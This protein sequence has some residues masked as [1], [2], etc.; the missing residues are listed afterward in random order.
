[1]VIKTFVTDFD[2][3]TDYNQSIFRES[4]Y[5]KESDFFVGKVLTNCIEKITS[6]II[7]FDDSVRLYLS[8]VDKQRT[9]Y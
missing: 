1:M 6:G 2:V 5:R 7:Q 9:I 3:D 8:E 4:G